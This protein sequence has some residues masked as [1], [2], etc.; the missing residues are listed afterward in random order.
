[1]PRFLPRYGMAPGWTRAHRPLT[2]VFMVICF[3]VTLAFRAD[4]DAQA[5]AYATGVL[6]VI[7]SASIAVTLAARRKRA[8][9]SR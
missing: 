2:L 8:E 7:T 9:A 1:M 6:A 4:V 5:G 3:L